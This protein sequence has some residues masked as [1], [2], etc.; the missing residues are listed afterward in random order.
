MQNIKIAA[1]VIALSFALGAGIAHAQFGIPKI[2][3]VGGAASGGSSVKAGD[4]AKNARNAMYSFAMANQGLLKAFGGY[5][6]LA[7]NQKL[8]EGMKIGD[9]AASKDDM[10]KIV[11]LTKSS[12]DA[13]TAKMAENAKLDADQKKVA[14][15]A[16]LDYVKGLVAS[17][18]LV[19]S[20]QDVAKNPAAMGMDAGVLLYTA[21]EV[22]SIISTGASTTSS[23]FKY[24]GANGVDLT[25]AKAAAGGLGV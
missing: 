13:L 8:L 15:A 14:A 21:K 7:A 25:E 17:K 11:T 5:A 3:G 4:L 19:G 12:S 2:P 6:D 9:A 18:N 22:P 24:L 20:L 10:E 1:S 16:T 23:L